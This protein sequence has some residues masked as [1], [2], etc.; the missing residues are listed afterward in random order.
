[1]CNILTQQDAEIL[2]PA[3]GG[4][5]RTEEQVLFT[6]KGFISQELTITLWHNADDMPVYFDIPSNNTNSD[7]DANSAI[8]TSGN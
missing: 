1:L 8:K 4:M 7:V 3:Q 6:M 2:G 5:Y